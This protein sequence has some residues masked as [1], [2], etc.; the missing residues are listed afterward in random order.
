MADHVVRPTRSNF[1]RSHEVTI[2]V[3]SVNVYNIMGVVE[4][5]PFLSKQETNPLHCLMAFTFFVLLGFL[6]ISYP[7]KPSAFQIHPK[8][9][10]LSV[11]S[12]L[13]YSFAFW[14]KLKFATR[15]DTFME[16]FGSLSIV[17]LVM[18]FFPHN[19]GICGYIIIYTIW[20]IYHVLVMIKP[21]FIVP[22]RNIRRRLRPILP[23]NSIDLN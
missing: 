22:R 21:Y 2:N 13:I 14:I 9:M 11:A 16:V 18:M 1:N 4:T 17:S 10:I 8:T 23:N 12:F 15:V 7:D 6:Q 3:V 5:N 20:F 19:W